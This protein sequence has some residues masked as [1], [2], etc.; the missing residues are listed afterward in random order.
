MHDI[1]ILIFSV[2]DAVWRTDLDWIVVHRD[3]LVVLS[4]MNPAGNLSTL[5]GLVTPQ[6][7]ITLSPEEDVEDEGLMGTTEPA[8]LNNVS[9]V[10]K[11][12]ESNKSLFCPTCNRNSNGV[13]ENIYHLLLNNYLIFTSRIIAISLGRA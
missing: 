1:A 7:F 2:P 13:S 3:R 5:S 12:E 9:V 11:L 4:F 10:S 6:P 8:N